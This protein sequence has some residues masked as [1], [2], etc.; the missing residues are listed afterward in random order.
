MIDSVAARSNLFT[1]G[2]RTLLAHTST[3]FTELWRRRQVET[4]TFNKCLLLHGSCTRKDEACE[5]RCYVNDLDD[6]GCTHHFTSQRLGSNAWH[7]RMED[8]ENALD[9]AVGVDDVP[10][11]KFLEVEAALKEI[12]ER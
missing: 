6:N 1:L 9:L 2:C 8:N 3:T 5:V 12:D 10:S 4:T 11:D 7:A